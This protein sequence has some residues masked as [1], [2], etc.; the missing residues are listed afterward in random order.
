MCHQQ[1]LDRSCH[2]CTAHGRD[3]HTD[4][5][6][7]EILQTGVRVCVRGMKNSN[8]KKHLYYTHV[9]TFATI[10]VYGVGVVLV[11]VVDS[12]LELGA[13]LRFLDGQAIQVGVGVQCKLVHRVNGSH[14]VQHKEQ[15]GCT[16]GA[17]TVTLHRSVYTTPTYTLRPAV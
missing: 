3:Q 1:H 10:P 8:R 9:Y 11:E 12:L 17:R 4:T 6:T 14:V 2:F 13:A 7:T 15:D 5:E 16:L